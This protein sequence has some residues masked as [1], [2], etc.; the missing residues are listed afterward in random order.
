LSTLEVD[1]VELS[2]A[3]LATKFGVSEDQVP[4]CVDLVVALDYLAKSL[5]SCKALGLEPATALRAIGIEIPAFAG[6]LLN[7]ALSSIA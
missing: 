2:T 6:P 4:A 3:E 7:S 1:G 5:R